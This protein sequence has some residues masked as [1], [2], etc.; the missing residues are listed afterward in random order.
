M[1]EEDTPP[2]GLERAKSLGDAGKDEEKTLRN[3]AIFTGPFS[4]AKKKK[5]KERNKILL[6]SNNAAFKGE[7]KAKA[8]KLPP[9]NVLVHSS[10]SAGSSGRS[11]TGTGTPAQGPR[12]R[13]PIRP[14][15]KE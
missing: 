3:R 9:K 15:E 12:T 7:K 5:E 10:P 2:G 6:E 14:R 8:L 4:F 1:G 13:G 11:L